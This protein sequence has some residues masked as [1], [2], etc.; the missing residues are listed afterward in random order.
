M[1]YIVIIIDSLLVASL[2]FALIRFLLRRHPDVAGF[3]FTDAD[4]KTLNETFASAASF[5]KNL[6]DT[7]ANNV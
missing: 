5:N 1:I 4:S 7:A 6:K 3:L 2:L